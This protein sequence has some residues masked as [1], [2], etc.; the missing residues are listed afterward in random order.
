MALPCLSLGYLLYERSTS[1]PSFRS[2]LH[3]YCISHDLALTL[4]RRSELQHPYISV[5]G[6][7][8]ALSEGNRTNASRFKGL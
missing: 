7:L 4:T 6:N 3:H 5:W 1:C 8:L 2:L